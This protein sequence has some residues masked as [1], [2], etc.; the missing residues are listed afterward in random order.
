MIIMSEAKKTLY[1]NITRRA[2]LYNAATSLAISTAF[3]SSLVGQ[4]SG[5]SQVRNIDYS[6]VI[7]SIR[8]LLPVSMAR[9]DI[10]GAAVALIDGENIV[11]TEGF[12]YTDRTRLVRVTPDTPFSIGS[13]SKSFTATGILR[14]VDKGLL[15]LDDPVKRHLP[16]FTVN[17]RTGGAE[18]ERITIRHLLSHHSGLGTW[19]PLGNPHDP[20]YASRTFEEVVRSTRASWLKF[21]PGERF[22]YCNQGIDLAGFA[23]QVAANKP[24]EDYMR[25]E[26]FAPLDMT[27]STFRQRDVTQTPAF[28]RG[29]LGQRAIPLTNGVVH[30]LLAAGGMIST[31]RDMARFVSFQLRAETSGRG[32]ISENLLRDMRAPQLTAGNQISGYGLCLYKA[33]EHDTVR[34]S[35]GGLGY[36][37]STHYR[38]LPEHG[39]GAVVLTNQSSAHNAP[40]LAS[41][42]I[43]MMLRAKLGRLP[44]K[45]SLAPT[46]RPVV[47]LDAARLRRLE[48]TYLLYEGLL[49]RFKVENG[50]L[51]HIIGSENL[52][53][54]ARSQTE[55]TS[56]SRKYTFLFDEQGRPRGVQILDPYYDPSFAE[57]SVVYMPVNDT[58]S[59]ERGSNK[60]EWSRH[61]G[62]YTGTFIGS[63]SE[64]E[65]KVKNGHLYLVWDGER[66]LFE[67]RPDLFFTAD[68]EAVIF[69]NDR[70]SIG[71][72]LY[73]KKR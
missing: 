7:A 65:V 12:G 21:P 15:T 2:F 11:C 48:G 29:Y 61:V 19:S 22:E 47:N 54:E 3:R 72:R 41:Q 44:Q 57:N 8:L 66:R 5:V 45:R 10:T 31:A 63:S 18:A 53:L 68:G 56:G 55:F 37:I 9:K 26:I 59:D 23:L 69:E 62:E 50:Q 24:F 32:F 70:L 4:Q 40:G 46:D 30:P 20:Q 6:S 35:H 58:P 43:E 71:N 17:N 64:A 49:Y 14:A 33:V 51:I 52:R 25:E 60:R 27:A 36:G 42:A 67:H 28:A 73:N 34:F 39:I 13:I 38:Y 1:R 16:W